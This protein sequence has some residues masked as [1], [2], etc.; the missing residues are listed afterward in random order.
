[1][2]E[3]VEELGVTWDVHR[4]HYLGEVRGTN[5]GGGETCNCYTMVFRMEVSDVSFTPT[6]D[7]A[8][9][10]AF[11]IEAV[12][13]ALRDGRGLPATDGCERQFTENF[14][15]VFE[16]FISPEFGREPLS[17]PGEQN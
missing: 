17:T 10:M 4:A 3:V 5:T 7:V 11:E 14:A 2:H 13:R 15:A 6:P 1:M 8:E 12:A 9:V 16:R